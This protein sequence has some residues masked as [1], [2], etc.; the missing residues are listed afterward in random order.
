MFEIVLTVFSICELAT[1]CSLIAR[2][3]GSGAPSAYAVEIAASPAK[4]NRA[5]MDKVGTGF[6]GIACLRFRYRGSGKP[7]AFRPHKAAAHCR[8]SYERQYARRSRSRR[9]PTK[10]HV[11]V[12][13]GARHIRRAGISGGALIMS[14]SPTHVSWRLSRISHSP[15]TRAAAPSCYSFRNWLRMAIF[16]VIASYWLRCAVQYPEQRSPPARPVQFPRPESP[17]SLP[18]PDACFSCTVTE[19]RTAPDLATWPLNFIRLGWLTIPSATLTV[20]V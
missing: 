5:L 1:A 18:E 13:N 8:N 3:I 4:A 10:R 12:R 7:E 20:K 9:E 16:T 6:R 14:V 11:N 19:A 2:C 15:F 17:V